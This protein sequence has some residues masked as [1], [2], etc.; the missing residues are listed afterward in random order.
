MDVGKAQGNFSADGGGLG[1]AT[2]GGGRMTLRLHADLILP[3][4]FEYDLEQ[5]KIAHGRAAVP[6]EIRSAIANT[7]ST[8]LSRLR[9]ITGHQ[10]LSPARWMA[11]PQWIARPSYT[12]IRSLRGRWAKPYWATECRRPHCYISVSEQDRV[13]VIDFA[14]AKEIASVKVGDHPQR[15]R[16]GKLRLVPDSSSGRTAGNR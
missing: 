11:T 2:D 5:D 8:P 14:T 12:I 3:G 1:R 4:F 6:E 9:S 13:A 10:T 16:T 15:V 7:S